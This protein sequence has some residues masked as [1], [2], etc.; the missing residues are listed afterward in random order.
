MK[1]SNTLFYVHI[2][3]P[4]VHLNFFGAQE[5]EAHFVCAAAAHHEAAACGTAQSYTQTGFRQLID[6][7]PPFCFAPF[8]CL[9]AESFLPR[10]LPAL[11]AI[12]T[13]FVL[14]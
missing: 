14:K 9:A 6:R 12:A 7:V 13:D 4:G 5:V 3:L 8:S 1:K 11:L 2:S 10:S